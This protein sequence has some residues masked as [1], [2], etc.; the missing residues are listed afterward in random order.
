MKWGWE[1]VTHHDGQPVIV[2]LRI[3]KVFTQSR[4]AIREKKEGQDPYGR[5]LDV[6]ITPLG[7]LLNCPA[8]LSS[9]PLT[10]CPGPYRHLQPPAASQR[11]V[12]GL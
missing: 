4:D 3:L 11:T 6:I 5:D 12:A 10:P 1:G 9:V 2:E 8:P 7:H